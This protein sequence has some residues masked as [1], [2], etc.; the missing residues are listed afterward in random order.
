MFQVKLGIKLVRARIK[1]GIAK[2]LYPHFSL[3]C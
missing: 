3:N 1:S 2:H